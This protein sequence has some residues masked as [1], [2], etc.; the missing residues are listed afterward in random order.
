[1]VAEA[2][3]TEARQL[4]AVQ[5][6]A[7]EEERLEGDK[8]DEHADKAGQCEAHGAVGRH[9]LANQFPKSAQRRRPPWPPHPGGA[10]HP[11]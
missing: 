6:G 7:E 4:C 2:G 5:P 9:R 8:V 3:E 11:I 1:M 10:V